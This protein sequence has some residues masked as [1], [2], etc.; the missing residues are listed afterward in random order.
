MTLECTDQPIESAM[1]PPNEAPH[2]APKPN[3]PFCK[4]WYMPR[5]RNGIMSEFTIVATKCVSFAM[6]SYH[7]RTYP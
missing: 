7:E 6:T 1:D 4:A 3:M 5:F 2:M